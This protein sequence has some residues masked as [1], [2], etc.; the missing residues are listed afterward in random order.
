MKPVGQVHVP[1]A[2][3]I[4]APAHDGEQ[5]VDWMS[6]RARSPVFGSCETSGTASQKTTRV[7]PNVI[8]AQT[9]E[10]R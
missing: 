4:P 9:L 2:V 8:A 6:N 3:Q 5:A 1:L 10:E 7:S